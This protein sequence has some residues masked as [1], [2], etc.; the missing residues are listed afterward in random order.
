MRYSPPVELVDEDCVE[1]VSLTR[2]ASVLSN[3]G[4]RAQVV[5][6]LAE[7]LSTTEVAQDMNTSP[8]TVRKWR[9]RSLREGVDG[10]WDDARSG[11]PPVV[12]EAEVVIATR[13]PAPEESGVT[14]W[15]S[16]ELV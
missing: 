2:R 16:R 8:P 4:F 3:V 15:S 10:L 6:A 9:D 7:G 12:N 13:E 11:R 5:L 1:L 14:H